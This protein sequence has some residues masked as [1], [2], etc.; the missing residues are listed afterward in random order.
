MQR[1]IYS[2]CCGLYETAFPTLPFQE[3]LPQ[4]TH[5]ALLTQNLVWLKRPRRCLYTNW[6]TLMAKAVI[7][8]MFNPW[9][10]QSRPAHFW[11]PEIVCT[12]CHL[13]HESGFDIKY[14]EDCEIE[15]LHQLNHWWIQKTSLGKLVNTTLWSRIWIAVSG[16]PFFINILWRCCGFEAEF[17]MVFKS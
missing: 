10:F 6:C 11:K 2:C 3:F 5:N 1:E 16:R 13:T 7:S 15:E 9:F 8:S 12:K 14:R 17:L 4:P